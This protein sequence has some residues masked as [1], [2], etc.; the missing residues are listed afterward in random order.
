MATLDIRE[1]QQEEITEIKFDNSADVIEKSRG[2]L[3]F[4]AY[5]EAGTSICEY[6]DLDN[7]IVACKKAKELWGK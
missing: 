5:G 2:H 1:E 3:V 7:F 6:D 4:R